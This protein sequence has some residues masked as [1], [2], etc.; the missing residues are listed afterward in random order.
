LDGVTDTV[1]EDLEDEEF[2]DCQVWLPLAYRIGW[3]IN[4]LS[5][6]STTT[7]TSYL[8]THRTLESLG[9]V[10]TK[11]KSGSFKGLLG[12]GDGADGSAKTPAHVG[13]RHLSPPPHWR[14][15]LPI[16]PTSGWQSRSHKTPLAATIKH[17]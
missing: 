7:P 1:K 15:L 14:L 13:G 8:N 3:H 4:M 2:F 9:P 10:S 6:E 11:S 5:F 12:R 16:N 17:F